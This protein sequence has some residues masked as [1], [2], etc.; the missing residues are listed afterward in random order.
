MSVAM[1]VVATVAGVRAD[2]DC[3]RRRRSNNFKTLQEEQRTMVMLTYSKRMWMASLA[4]SLIIFGVVYFTVIRPDNN[5]ANNAIKAGLQQ[6][7]Q[8][9]NQAQ[10]QLSNASNQAGAASGAASSAASGAS[11]TASKVI[12]K[13]AKLTSCVAA[14]GTDTTKLAACQSQFGN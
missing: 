12:N 11:T 2:R 1:S 10:Q 8:A 14:A 5:T 9:L 7:Q 13:A 3:S 6:S 4:V